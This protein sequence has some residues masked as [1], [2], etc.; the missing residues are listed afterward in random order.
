MKMNQ[1]DMINNQMQMLMNNRNNQIQN[2]NHQ[3]SDKEKINDKR[4][5]EISVIFRRIQIFSL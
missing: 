1:I 5:R 4:K 3:V 2:N